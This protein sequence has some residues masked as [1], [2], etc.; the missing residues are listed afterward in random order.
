LGRGRRTPPALLYGCGFYTSAEK[1]IAAAL[2]GS[3]W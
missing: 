1:R 3:N 2:Q